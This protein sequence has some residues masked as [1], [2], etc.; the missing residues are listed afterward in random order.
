[1][2]SSTAAARAHDRLT[3]A[4]YG[5]TRAMPLTSGVA[6]GGGCCARQAAG[7]RSS[8]YLRGMSGLR[9]DLGGNGPRG[10]PQTAKVKRSCARSGAPNAA[11]A[12][13]SGAG[14]P[15]LWMSAGPLRLEAREARPRHGV[16]QPK[17]LSQRHCLH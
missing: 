11:I 5:P 14:D 10:G 4:G 1:H 9:F 8:P 13:L 2:T 12:V 6:A 7:A 15:P 3:L 16:D 17:L